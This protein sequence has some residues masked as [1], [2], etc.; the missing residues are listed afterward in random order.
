MPNIEP[1][2]PPISAIIKS[3]D[4]GIRHNL[5][6]AHLLSI[7]MIAKPIKLIK[8]KYTAIKLITIICFVLCYI[9]YLFLSVDSIEIKKKALKRAFLMNYLFQHTLFLH[10]HS[11]NFAGKTKQIDK[12]FRIMVVIQVSC[13]E[14]SNAF[15]I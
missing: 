9:L 5:F 8:I 11:T 2:L 4:S 7:P 3:V 12:S 1:I 14:G 15:V 6:M 13:C 10:F